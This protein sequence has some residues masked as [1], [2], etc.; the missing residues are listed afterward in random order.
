[1]IALLVIFILIIVLSITNI[2]C[3]IIKLTDCSKNEKVTI[4]KIPA[5]LLSEICCVK[6]ED[7]KE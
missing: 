5:D 1:M 4:I 6:K 7:N 3:Q 2:I